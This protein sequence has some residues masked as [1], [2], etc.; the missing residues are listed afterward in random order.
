ML[1][2]ASCQSPQMVNGH[3]AYPSQ[4]AREGGNPCRDSLFLRLKNKPE[5]ELTAFER[6]YFQQKYNECYAADSN[7]SNDGNTP[8]WIAA[9]ILMLEAAAAIVVFVIK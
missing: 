4:M 9:I 5:A 1:L 7:N 2:L 3:W 8:E 6:A